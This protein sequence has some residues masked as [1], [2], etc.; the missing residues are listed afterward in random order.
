MRTPIENTDSKMSDDDLCALT[1]IQGVFAEN[2]YKNKSTI[3]GA[4]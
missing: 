4:A 2:N 3:I 1:Y